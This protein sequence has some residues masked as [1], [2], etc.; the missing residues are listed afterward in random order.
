MI[1]PTPTGPREARA[2]RMQEQAPVQPLRRDRTGSERPAVSD[3]VELSST[4][5]EIQGA[6][7]GGRVAGSQ[8]SPDRMGRILERMQS[9]YYDQ[10]AVRDAIL[11][12]VAA[13]SGL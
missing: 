2:G 4:A 9:G 5:Q 7:L 13:E 3:R 1:Q 11:E 10:P 6:S 8:L 12:R